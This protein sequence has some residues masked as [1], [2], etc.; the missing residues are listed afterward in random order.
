MRI[1]STAYDPENS[2]SPRSSEP[3]QNGSA[4]SLLYRTQ[5]RQLLRFCRVRIRSEADAEDI[6]QSAFLAARRAYPD[7]GAEELRPLLFT[8]VRNLSLNHLKLHWNKLRC[9]EDISEAVAG[10]ACPQSPTPEKQLMDAQSG[11]LT[12]VGAGEHCSM[13]L[14]QRTLERNSYPHVFSGSARVPR[15]HSFAVRR[16]HDCY[17]VDPWRQSHPVELRFGKAAAFGCS[18]CRAR[19]RRPA[20]PRCMRIMRFNLRFHLVAASRSALR[21]AL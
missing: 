2:L 16:A 18:T 5:H 19:A 15:P 21:M 12:G 10:L 6:V 1:S 13:R 17:M 11:D 3:A 14:P 20:A 8:L 7:K 4:L 9:G